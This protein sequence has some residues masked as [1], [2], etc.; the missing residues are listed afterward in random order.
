MREGSVGVELAS[1]QV[2]RRPLVSG[3]M[4]ILAAVFLAAIPQANAVEIVSQAPTE[5]EA[6][7]A[8]SAT[9]AWSVGYRDDGAEALTLHWDGRSW[10]PV[11][12]SVS[13]KLLGVSALSPTDAW[14]VGAYSA[15]RS[16]T[17]QTLVL[18]W[19]GS[20]WTRV[21]SPNST[22]SINQLEGVSAVSANDAWAVGDFGRPGHPAFHSLIL[23]WNGARWSTVPAPGGELH[24]VS[25]VSSRSAWAVGF[26]TLLHWNG[27]RWSRQSIRTRDFLETVPVSRLLGVSAL[28]SRNVWAVGNRCAHF[29]ACVARTE[30]IHWNGARWSPVSS[31][32]PSRFNNHL[33]GVSALSAGNAWAVGAYCATRDC[34]RWHTLAVR[35]NGR[36]WSTVPS[37]NPSSSRN[38]LAG[39]EAIS[40]TQA[41]AVGDHGGGSSGTGTLLLDWNGTGWSA[42]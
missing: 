7:S 15:P 25:G 27:A 32:A 42:L 37:P 13:A 16:H 8:T 12:N 38:L 33:T 34:F 22:A 39:V 4:L 5:L 17:V 14:A 24:A 18:R 31:P 2:W 23:H 6:V 30:I 29:G 19:D 20:T 28:S 36:R 26:G 35:W 1:R 11:P 41:L 9:D 40:P 21:P 10:S 3:A